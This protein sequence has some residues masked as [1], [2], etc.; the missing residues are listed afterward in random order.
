MM[1]RWCLVARLNIEN[2][3]G[4]ASFGRD[5]LVGL[6]DSSVIDCLMALSNPSSL[7]QNAGFMDIS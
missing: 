2:G 3:P 4:I 7:D 6:I 5:L 1:E